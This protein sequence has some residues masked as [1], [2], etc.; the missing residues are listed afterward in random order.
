MVEDAKRLVSLMG[1][2][3]VQ[4]KGEAEAQCSNIT[5]NGKAYATASEDMDSLTFGS[6]VLIRGL[7]KNKTEDLIEISL[8]SVL[9]GLNLTMD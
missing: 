9:N 2:P 4:A 1:F 5:L 7:G 8:N 3:V 6:P